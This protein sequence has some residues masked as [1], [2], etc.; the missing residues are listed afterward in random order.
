MKCLT[1]QVDR[2]FVTSYGMMPGMIY[3]QDHD[4]SRADAGIS[5]D[6][7]EPVLRLGDT[8]VNVSRALLR[9]GLANGD[10]TMWQYRLF[11]H[12]ASIQLGRDGYF[13]LI[14]ERA[15]DKDGALVYFDVGSGIHAT[16]EYETKPFES[17]ATGAINSLPWIGHETVMLA[18]L[19][20]GSTVKAHRYTK[21]RIFWGD[22]V[23]KQTLAYTFDGKWL[24]M[25]DVTAR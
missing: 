12:R 19:K 15:D 3:V 14:P 6:A 9:Q 2:R 5:V 13:E 25:R 24:Q 4:P 7:E 22:L 1:M 10:V 17:I 23:R 18:A 20:P 11:I 21:R 8:Q 16:V